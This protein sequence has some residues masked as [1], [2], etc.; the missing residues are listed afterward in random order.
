MARAGAEE[1]PPHTR[2][3]RYERIEGYGGPWN[4]SWSMHLLEGIE[5][6]IRLVGTLRAPY[7]VLNSRI[8]EYGTW[9]SFRT[10]MEADA[11][12]TSFLTWASTFLEVPYEWGGSWYGGRVGQ[13]CGAPDPYDGYGMDCSGLICAAAYWA[14]YRWTTWRVNTEG[15]EDVSDEIS[16]GD[17]RAGDILNKPN[18]HVVAIWR[19]RSGDF[20]DVIEASPIACEVRIRENVNMMTVYV[21]N[22]YT[23]RRLRP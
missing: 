2:D 6:T 12:G 17:A 11:N 14:G 22:G 15:L 3:Y 9:V 5:G 23:P 18:A 1:D 16:P 21:G 13:N 20:V 8:F 7:G 10:Q 4:S 19:R